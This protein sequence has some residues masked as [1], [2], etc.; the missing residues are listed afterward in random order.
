M[1]LDLDYLR[2]VTNWIKQNL[3]CLWEE[4][5]NETTDFKGII[6]IGTL[7]YI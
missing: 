3:A 1:L 4:T 6:G 5:K 2:K 7:S